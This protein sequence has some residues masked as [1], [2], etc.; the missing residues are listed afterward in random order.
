MILIMF[1]IS[2]SSLFSCLL[3]RLNRF[4]QVYDK[5][6][7]FFFSHLTSLNYSCT[8]ESTLIFRDISSIFSTLSRHFYLLQRKTSVSHFPSLK[9][10]FIFPAFGFARLF[11]HVWHQIYLFLLQT[12][13][14]QD[15]LLPRNVQDWRLMR[16]KLRMINTAKCAHW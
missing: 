1:T 9:T 4:I 13:V 11:S 14:T 15:L 6:Q 7:F 10:S 5:L 8:P 16:L 3:C 12:S 2:K